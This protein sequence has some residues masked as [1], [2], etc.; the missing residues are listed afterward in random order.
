[1]RVDVQRNRD[2]GVSK[3]LRDNLGVHA[4]L[5]QQRGVDVAEVMEPESQ[6]GLI[7]YPCPRFTQPV[8]VD[9][10]SHGI[11]KYEIVVVVGRPGSKTFLSLPHPLLA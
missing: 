8:R 11:G 6:P 7:P 10:F 2:C 3:P 4:L 5:K 9:R 1:M